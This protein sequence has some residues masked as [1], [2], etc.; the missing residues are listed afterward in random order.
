METFTKVRQ[1]ISFTVYDITFI[2]NSI[3]ESQDLENKVLDL[4]DRL[5]QYWIQHRQGTSFLVGPNVTE[6]AISTSF[7]ELFNKVSNYKARLYYRIL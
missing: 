1:S 6:S 3:I 7:D 5:Y 4:W 2:V